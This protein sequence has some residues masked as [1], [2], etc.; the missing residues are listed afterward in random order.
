M[1]KTDV[2][3]IAKAEGFVDDSFDFTI[4]RLSN[5]FVHEFNPNMILSKEVTADEFKEIFFRAQG[6]VRNAKVSTFEFKLRYFSYLK[7]PAF[8]KKLWLRRKRVLYLMGIR[9]SDVYDRIKEVVI[10]E[11]VLNSHSVKVDTSSS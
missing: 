9:K 4:N 6:I 3:D 11:P 8:V 10:K 2:W 7:N 5:L 1:P